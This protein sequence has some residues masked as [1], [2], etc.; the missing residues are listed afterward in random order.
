[1]TE[2]KFHPLCLAFPEMP[3]EAYERRRADY[4]K[5]PDR[6]GDTQVLLAEHEGE[7]KILDGRHH[8]LICKELGYPCQFLRVEGTPDELADIAEA[9]GINRRHQTESQIAAAILALNE[10]RRGRP[11]K[12]APVP[13]FSA[14]PTKRRAKTQPD[15]AR[16]SGISERTIRSASAAVK[17]EPALLAALRDG[18][19][20][21]K[22]AARVA[23]LPEAER[24]RV[25]KAKDPKKAAKDA[26]TKKKGGEEASG[27]GD[28][29]S[30]LDGRSGQEGEGEEKDSPADGFVALVETLCRDIDQ[31]AGRLKALKPDP[32]S[33]SMHID[34]A[35]AQVEAA[36]KTLWQGRPAHDCPYCEGKGCKTCNQ[37]GRV[38]KTTYDSGR[39]AVG[40]GK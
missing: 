38:K 18:K 36:R 26:L 21:A 17:A 14:N 29:L 35:V 25:A 31:I 28:W 10:F 19:I 20:D 34:S 2:Y 40:G 12:P 33:Y 37:T 13:V 1:M 8:Y 16:A 4:G 24:K 30:G 32:L 9:R 22:T 23:K 39:E 27:P 3:P 6:A 15:A 7:W 5:H 11:E